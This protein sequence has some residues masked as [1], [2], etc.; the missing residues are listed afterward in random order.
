MIRIVYSEQAHK[1]L[2]L[3][4]LRSTQRKQERV[5]YDSLEQKLILLKTDPSKGIK[6]SKKKIPKKYIIQYNVDNLWKLNL[7]ILS[8]KYGF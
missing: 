4:A 2:E 3:L 7:R 5:L 8:G 1:V 6:I